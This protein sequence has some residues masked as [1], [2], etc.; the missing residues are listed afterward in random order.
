MA[1]SKNMGTV[2]Q[3]WV[4]PKFAREIKELAES[5]GRSVSNLIKLALRERLQ[6][7]TSPHGEGTARGGSSDPSEGIRRAAD[8]KEE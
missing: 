6:A 1:E 8:A 7:E 5:D 4:T 3:S 2:I